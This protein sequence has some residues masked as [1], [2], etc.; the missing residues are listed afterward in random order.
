MSIFDYVKTA[1]VRATDAQQ[2]RKRTG[3][4]EAA[5]GYL[6]YGQSGLAA[7]IDRQRGMASGFVVSPD[8][9]PKLP[10]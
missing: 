7:D 6:S 9:Y 2:V 10:F 5:A 4:D 3:S 1:G 8:D